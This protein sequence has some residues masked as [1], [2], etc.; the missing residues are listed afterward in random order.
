VERTTCLFLILSIVARDS[1][2]LEPSTK[3]HLRIKY[4]LT[5][6]GTRSINVV[7]LIPKIFDGEQMV[8]NVTFSESPLKVFEVE[9]AKYAEFSFSTPPL[10]VNLEINATVHRSQDV[11]WSSDLEPMRKRGRKVPLYNSRGKLGDF[12]IDER[13]IEKSNPLIRQIASQ[14]KA[15]DEIDTIKNTLF[16]LR[17]NFKY[18]ADPSPG[19]GGATKLVDLKVGD[20]S[21]FTDLF[22]ALCR[23][24]EIPSRAVRGVMSYKNIPSK[25]AWAEVHLKKY[26]WFQVDPTMSTMKDQES[27]RQREAFYICMTKL[28]NDD[29]ICNYMFGICRWQVGKVR[30]DDEIEMTVE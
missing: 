21:E 22:V 6:N 3:F 19:G 8:K 15:E 24:N 2:K 18:R 14:V 27:P 1:P 23:S 7:S 20:C 9:G 4:S 30:M 10:I 5:C 26:G 25:H 28:R 13:Y 11:L 17:D 12:L 29:T 16:Y